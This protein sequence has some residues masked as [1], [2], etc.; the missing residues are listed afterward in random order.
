[1]IK[2]YAPG[3]GLEVVEVSHE[4]GATDPDRVREAAVD[5]AA[6]IFQQPNF[7]GV[8]ENAPELAAAANE[9]GAMPIAHVD[10]VSLGVL[11]REPGTSAFR[12]AAE[13]TMFE[14]T[15]EPSTGSNT[16]GATVV[17]RGEVS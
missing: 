9:A 7:F 3:F 8:L 16:P 14:V 10:L 6:V 2:T 12:L 15:R 13:P 1:M 5:A 17:M 11:G 4:G